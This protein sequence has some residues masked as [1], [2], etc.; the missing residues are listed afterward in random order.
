MSIGSANDHRM[1]V[2]EG[3]FFLN[4]HPGAV[5][6][7]PLHRHRGILEGPDPAHSTCTPRTLAAHHW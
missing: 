7:Y 3:E 4:D 1:L 2:S 5:G 6:T